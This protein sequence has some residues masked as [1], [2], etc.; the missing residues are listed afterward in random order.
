M[1]DWMRPVGGDGMLRL[2]LGQ[3]LANVAAFDLTDP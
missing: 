2:D 1:I 3:H